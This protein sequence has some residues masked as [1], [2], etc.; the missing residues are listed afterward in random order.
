LLGTTTWPQGPWLLPT[1]VGIKIPGDLGVAGFDD[2]PVATTVWPELTTVHQPIAEMAARS[3]NI[4]A[5]Q[6]SDTRWRDP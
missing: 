6:G 3:V 5:D 1:G 4:L 2:A